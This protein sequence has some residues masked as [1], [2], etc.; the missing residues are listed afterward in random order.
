MLV[1][2]KWCS[3]GGGP[4]TGRTGAS[5]V[6]ANCTWRPRGGDCEQMQ[7][8][9]TNIAQRRWEWQEDR[10]GVQV[11]FTYQKTFLASL[12]VW[13]AF[14]VVNAAVVARILTSMEEHEH[15]VA[16]LLEKMKDLR[17]SACFENCHG[18]SGRVGWT[19]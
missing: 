3:G 17:V 5:G 12:D 15:A 6:E 9:V 19:P 10:T 16:A 7:S 8:S 18:V 11:F 13:T 2:A 4:V 1:L 14:D